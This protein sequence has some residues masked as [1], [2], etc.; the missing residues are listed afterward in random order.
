MVVLYCCKLAGR[1]MIELDRTHPESSLFPSV[2]SCLRTTT[3]LAQTC[4]TVPPGD[5]TSYLV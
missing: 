1:A 5:R 3:T 4:L 2:V